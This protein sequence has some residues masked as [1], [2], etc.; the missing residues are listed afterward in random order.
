MLKRVSIIR[1]GIKILFCWA[2]FIPLL[3]GQDAHYWTNQYGTKA[4]LLGGAVV[5]SV[6]DLSSVYYNPGALPSIKD[7]TMVLTTAAF[8]L[9]SF[10]WKNVLNSGKTLKYLQLKP[11]PI[12]FAVRVRLGGLQR[13]NWVV[14]YLNRHNV[15]INLE[16]RR[17]S[18]AMERSL[19]VLPDNLQ[20]DEVRF[21]QRINESWVGVTWAYKYNSHISLGVTQFF[22]LRNQ[23]MRTH[24]IW[25]AVFSDSTNQSQIFIDEFSY[26]AVR[27]FWKIGG[28]LDYSPLTVG[29]TL[30]TPG[31]H[32]LGNGWDFFTI[33]SLNSAVGNT[34]VSS[35]LYAYSR[36]NMKTRF[37][38]PIALSF[39]ASYRL[40]HIQL[41]FT[42]E[43]FRKI[44]L[45]AVLSGE[46]QEI[47]PGT[48]VQYPDIMEEMNSVFNW[49]VAAEHRFS[50]RFT[51][52]SGFNVDRSGYTPGSN[53]RLSVTSWD[54]Y[55]F[56]LGSAFFIWNSYF[57]LGFSYSFG[58][59]ELKMPP[60]FSSLIHEWEEEEPLKLGTIYS[61]QLRILLGF[62]V[63]F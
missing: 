15:L 3:F 7:S 37:K 43:W 46:G 14:S 25:Q 21:H 49:G 20:F 35:R 28:F 13:S 9:N 26:W 6:K 8:E 16:G 55:H 54:I 48:S 56:T 10:H 2:L 19:D 27:T 50:S 44:P 63:R 1:L 47:T 61:Q 39:G 29:I 18:P 17:V 5:G 53:S 51:L 31:F 40:N 36:E 22:A 38:S 30:T 52:Y 60:Y 4:Q 24:N 45:Y 32:I 33:S 62:S 42:G 59:E 41:H 12:I 57:T 11:S 23:R 58:G 34:N